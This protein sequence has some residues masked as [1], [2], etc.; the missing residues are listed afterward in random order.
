MLEYRISSFPQNCASS[1]F[2]SGSRA[3]FAIPG[4]Q[5]FHIKYFSAATPRRGDS[6]QFPFQDREHTIAMSLFSETVFLFQPWSTILRIV[7][8]LFP[9]PARIKREETHFWNWTDAFFVFSRLKGYVKH[10]ERACFNNILH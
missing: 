7:S 4:R 9:L 8:S 5:L 10:Y 6:S 2:Y 1:D 3:C